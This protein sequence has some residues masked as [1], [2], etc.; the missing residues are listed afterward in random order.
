[1]LCVSAMSFICEQKKNAC[2]SERESEMSTGQHVFFISS[3]WF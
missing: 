3:K 2:S 1:M